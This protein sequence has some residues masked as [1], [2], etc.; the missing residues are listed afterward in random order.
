MKALRW[1]IILFIPV[2]LLLILIS[3]AFPGTLRFIDNYQVSIQKMVIHQMDK[4]NSKNIF[5]RKQTDSYTANAIQYSEL[6]SYLNDVQ[7]GT[8]FFSIHGRNVSK[9]FIKS[10]WKHC[11]I[12]LGTLHQIEHY[13]GGN[14]DLVKSLSPFYTTGDEYLIFDSSYNQGVSIHGIKK[15]AGL[16]EISTL[17][18]LLLFEFTLNKEEWSQ[19][20]QSNISQLGK[21][22]DYCF[23]LDNDD[24]L[25]CSEFLYEVLPLEKDYFN[26]SAKIIG[27]ELLLP[28]DLI[29]T[30]RHKGVSSGAFI[31]KACISKE[32]ESMIIHSLQ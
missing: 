6:T 18:R 24:A 8:L 17:R 14:H 3:F 32:G 28:S 22:Y 16:N 15:M 29:N 11:G 20:L 13:W 4:S 30:I 9:L 2:N 19:V 5:H 27:R 26:P 12:Y 25:Y 1:I 7:P 21:E 31:Y 10:D 23:V